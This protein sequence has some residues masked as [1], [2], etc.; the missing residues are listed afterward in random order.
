MDGI[1]VSGARL[2]PKEW[3]GSSFQP[4][5][6]WLVPKSGTAS[7]RVPSIQAGVDL[8][9]DGDTVLLS[10]GYFAGPGNRDIL[11]T[12]KDVVVRSQNGPEHC[13]LD[14]QGLGRAFRLQGASVTSATVIHGLT[15]YRGSASFGGGIECVLDCSPVIENCIF[16]QCDAAVGGGGGGIFYFTSPTSS[17]PGRVQDTEFLSRCLLVAAAP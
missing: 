5:R 17:L 14:C 2:G 1:H 8:A 15:I 10:D 12:G 11:V 7:I 3:K 16:I 13:I 9:A 4:G 6:V